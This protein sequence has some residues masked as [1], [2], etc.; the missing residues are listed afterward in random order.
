[1]IL[2]AFFSKLAN[3]PTIRELVFFLS[4]MSRIMNCGQTISFVSENESIIGKKEG[5]QNEHIF[6]DFTKENEVFSE[7]SRFL[8]LT[9]S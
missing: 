7:K 6:F 9:M 1:M 4:R 8:T 3:L 5:K 2:P